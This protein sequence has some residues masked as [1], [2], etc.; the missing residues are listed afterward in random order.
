LS[1]Y[2]G[3]QFN[4]GFG[5]PPYMPPL[6]PTRPAPPA[7]GGGGSS[8]PFLMLLLIIACLSLGVLLAWGIRER[9][10]RARLSQRN[11]E[12]NDAYVRVLAKRGDL[13][14]FLTDQ[15][16]RLY[17][18]SG[19]GEASGRSITVAW[20]EETHSGVLIGDRMPLIDARARYALWHVD[21]SQGSTAAGTFRPEPAG[22]FYD[23]RL[24]APVQGTAGF[25]V[26]VETDPSA[27][28]PGRV[29]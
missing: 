16:T 18:L 10:E 14:S 11:G 21:P 20:Q 8:R 23:F 24:T 17:R 13:A 1:N 26:S 12:L 22:T 15:K 27:T 2:G 25:R 28:R 9:G 7:P 5:R 4:A 19:R 29:D 3:H 6:P